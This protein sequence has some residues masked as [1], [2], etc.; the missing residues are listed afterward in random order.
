MSD[1]NDTQHR[2]NKRRTWVM[3]LAIVA[4]LFIYAYG[5][6]ATDVDLG[7]IEDE[8][9]Q[10]SLFRVLRAIA[11]PDLFERDLEE[12]AAQA[13][14]Y[15]P[16]G[17]TPSSPPDTSGPHL[18]L[19]P[20]C[21]DPNTEIQVQGVGFEPGA[22]GPLAFIPPS[23]VSLGVGDFEVG[24]DGTFTETIL[25]K[26][27][28]DEQV[29]YIRATARLEVGSLRFTQTARDT[30]DRALETI[31][32]ALLATTLG[33]AFAIP[34]SFLAS[35]NLMRSIKS[36][37]VSISLGIIALPI[38][39]YAGI[40]I[41]RLA[42]RAAD[43]FL[44]NAWFDL[45]GIAVLGA[46]IWFLMKL[47]FPE[48]ELDERPGPS[49]RLY[50]GILALITAFAFVTA[51]YLLADFLTTAG[52]ALEDTNTWFRK[53]NPSAVPPVGSGAFHFL[54]AFVYILGDMLRISTP[55]LTAVAGL[56]VF[57]Q[58]GAMFGRF[59][60]TR[61]PDA[62]DKALRY[63]TS[64][65]AG[66][67]VAIAIG[68]AIDWLYQLDDPM[69]TIWVPA[70]VG[71]VLGMLLAFTSRQAD[72]VSTGLTI[73][74]L[75][76]TVFNAMRSI[77]PLVMAIIFVI[78][79][80]IGPFAGALALSLHTM[81][82]LAKLYSEQVE[83]ISHGP[84]EAVQATGANRLQTIVYA[85]VPQIVPPYISFTLYRWDINVRMSTVIG[86]VGG[87]GLG[88]L[89]KQNVDLLNYRA[90]SAQMLAIAVIVAA[91]DYLS[92]RLRE[93]LV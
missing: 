58:F 82:A 17:T 48:E 63:L 53:G 31:F 65:L 79:V 56:G 44:D 8:Q 64:A 23:G 36:P 46:A 73:Y 52:H 41:A 29:Q 30:L 85:V 51:V 84:I 66:A 83:S 34:L 45:I 14:V 38:G 22:T 5:F 42:R 21:G 69:K 12:V 89:L 54:A 39:L 71:A 62:M 67:I 13:E 16:C 70:A 15:V 9:R 20:A 32:M 40:W 25:L 3:L 72:Q 33:T 19:T 10:T 55:L 91:M 78:W 37:M 74:Y 93:R 60:V 1:R 7:E 2:K 35:R 75:S 86:F 87:G 61:V 57:A 80:G 4:G 26:D 27:R 90:A 43:P 59:I 81:A 92:A 11:R 88:L 76:R 49:Q 18:I 77:E 47:L 6:Q 68:Q 50:R 28:P 24:D